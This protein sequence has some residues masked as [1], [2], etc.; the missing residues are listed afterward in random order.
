MRYARK[1]FVVE[2]VKLEKTRESIV[3]ALY[4]LGNDPFAMNDIEALDTII[5]IIMQR[6]GVYVTCGNEKRLAHFGAYI[7]RQAGDRGDNFMVIED[8]KF[9]E[10]YDPI[11]IG[12]ACPR[13]RKRIEIGHF[14]T[15]CE[16]CVRQ[17]NDSVEVE[18]TIKRCVEMSNDTKEK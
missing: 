3:D 15:L 17:L 7:C 11:D 4:F 18:K 5:V 14:T 10:M 6:G 2:G 16:A 1:P 12:Y 13:C 9:H 8:A